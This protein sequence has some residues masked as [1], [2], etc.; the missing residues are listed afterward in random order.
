MEFYCMTLK[1]GDVSKLDTR[2]TFTRMGRMH[3]A[4]DFEGYGC[5]DFSNQR[6][7]ISLWR[8]KTIS[9]IIAGQRIHRSTISNLR[10]NC[11]IFRYK[12]SESLSL[13]LRSRSIE[14][15]RPNSLLHPFRYDCNGFVQAGRSLE[16]AITRT[17]LGNFRS[18]KRAAIFQRGTRSIK[19]LLSAGSV[20]EWN[21][22]RP[23]AI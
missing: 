16:L 17:D 9:E 20:Q 5:L 15:Y 23:N 12:T 3:F 7:A 21:R 6:S 4:I 1:N 19:V 14:A 10:S 2:N 8:I 11:R 13:V 18:W 22:E